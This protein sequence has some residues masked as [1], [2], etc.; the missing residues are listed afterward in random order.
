MQSFQYVTVY[1]NN[2]NREAYNPIILDF[3]EK[4][5]MSYEAR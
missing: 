4:L 3:L 2:S 1:M 5:M